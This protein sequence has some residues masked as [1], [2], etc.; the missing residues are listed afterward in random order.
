[1]TSQNNQNNWLSIHLFYHDDLAIPILHWVH[2]LI[3]E[4]R[5]RHWLDKYFF[6]RY[7]QG[8][9]HIRLRLLPSS[10]VTFDEINAFLE[11]QTQD[12]LGTH[13]ATREIDP[14]HY[15]EATAHLSR[16]EYG[17]DQRVP[18]YPNNSWHYFPYEPEYHHYG[19]LAAMPAIE[20]FFM[21]SSD[22]ALDLLT[23]GLPHRSM[24]SYCLSTMLTAA[25]LST[26]DPAA[27]AR[28][29]ESH[30]HGWER[31]P[32]QLADQLLERFTNQ[33]ESQEAQVRALVAARLKM[34]RYD[35]D[36]STTPESPITRWLT[37]LRPCFAHLTSL[38]ETTP[39]SI[40]HPLPDTSTVANILMRCV[41]MHNNRLGVSLLEESYLLFLLK[42][43]LREKK[44]NSAVTSQTSLLLT[45]RPPVI[46]MP[47]QSVHLYYYAENKDDLL[48]D[49]IRPLF[50]QASHIAP[51][52]FFT[53]HWLRGPHIRLRFAC[54]DEQFQR[55]LKPLLETT[56]R[57]Y[58]QQHP[59]QTHL[60]EDRLRDQ[61]LLLASQEK[62]D[63]PLFP[64]YPDNT[65]QYIPYDPRINVLGSP[66]MSSILDDF[67]VGSTPLAFS[68]LEAL[69]QGQKLQSLCF[70]L[71]V[72]TAQTFGTHLVRGSISY[73]SHAEGFLLACTQPDEMRVSFEQKYVT[74]APVLT[75]RLSLLLNAL[76]QSADLFP[77]TLAWRNLLEAYRKRTEPLIQ[78]GTLN[79]MLP[80]ERNGLPEV[81]EIFR[82]NLAHSAFHSALESDQERKRT[83]YQDSWFQTYR[84]ILN[85]LYLHLSRLGLRPV[86]RF[87]LCH[88]TANAVEQQFNLNITEMLQQSTLQ[89]G[90]AGYIG[91]KE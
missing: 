11:K 28:L 64:F 19:G 32:R 44:G 86:E 42:E 46:D 8:G 45:K 14:Q 57:A 12:F 79:M 56:I 72:T 61:H 22:L 83:L 40:Q 39:L 37:A 66:L 29:F 10:E 89:G 87:L 58:L 33:Y 9:P 54:S 77:F 4:L 59:S 85:L 81:G 48:L 21:A 43:A 50:Q 23:Q 82:R 13:P 26:T 30:F 55:E 31:M 67:Y 41:H 34:V 68:M 78:G 20:T 1:M 3:A 51:R 88:L 53:R 71:M 63:G 90:H 74:Q 49:C 27:L 91:G 73:R 75:R 65:I 2:P 15:D 24:T 84:L 16:A 6:I 52:A 70:D 80:F 35:A 7:W 62:E 47:W 5:A 76:Q 36:L 18:L 60:D 69:R 25:A 17:T 38:D